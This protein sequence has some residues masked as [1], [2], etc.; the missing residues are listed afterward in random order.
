M[1]ISYVIYWRFDTASTD[2]V[3]LERQLSESEIPK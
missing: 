3:D 1:F 2:S